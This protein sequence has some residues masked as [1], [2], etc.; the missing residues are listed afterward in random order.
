M[1]VLGVMYVECSLMLS[2]PEFIT[3]EEREYCKLL[4]YCVKVDELEKRKESET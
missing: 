1:N 4:R 2:N 3:D